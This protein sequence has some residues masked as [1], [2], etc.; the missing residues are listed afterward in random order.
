MVFYVVHKNGEVQSL[1]FARIGGCLR[2]AARENG[3]V[4]VSEFARI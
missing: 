3:R 1:E 2:C 4:Q